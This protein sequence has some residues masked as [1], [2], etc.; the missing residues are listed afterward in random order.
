[1]INKILLITCTLIGSTLY[2]QNL[3]TSVLV[4][5]ASPS[6]MAAAIQSAKSG[7]KTVLIDA[8]NFESLT[9]SV[10]DKTIKAG[11]YADFVKRV[12]SLQKRPFTANQLL[13]PAFTASVFKGWADTVK[14]LTILSKSTIKKLK[15]SGKGWQ[16]DLQNRE[17]KADVLVDAS[18]ND[19][20]TRMVGLIAKRTGTTIS[21]SKLYDNNLYRT[22]VAIVKSESVAF[23]GFTLADF[24]VPEIENLVLVKPNQDVSGLQSGQAAGTIAAYCAFF[25]TSTK[26]ID[27]RKTQSELLT[28]KARLIHFDDIAE[29]DS[30]MI[31][32]QHIGVTGILKGKMEGN[33]FLFLPEATVSTEE[34]KKPFREYYSRS[35]IWFLDNQSPKL[36]I[37][38]ALSLIK[39][40]ASRGE[41]LNTQVQ[42]AWKSSLRLPGN[43]DLDK[44]ITRREFAILLDTYLQPFSVGV[45]LSGYV[46]N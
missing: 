20:L 17:I 15:K 33:K 45:D 19:A 39:F 44:T 25:K 13:T 41:E 5:G 2:A 21:S 24:I 30:S 31:A 8:G 38:G 11:I 10:Q 36:T 43:F 3:K 32:F 40:T 16:I 26:N 7:V 12:D 35:Q 37:K 46:K 6:G 27:V 22:S 29:A 23:K 4:V 34:L 14:N 9:L 28:F 42:K 18:S 1:M